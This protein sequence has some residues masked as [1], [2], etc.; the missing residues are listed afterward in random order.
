MRKLSTIQP[1]LLEPWL[2]VEHAKELQ[3]ISEILEQ[4]PEIQELILQDLHLSSGAQADTGADGLSADQVLRALLIKQ[5]NG[6]SYQELAFHLADSS[7]YRTFCRFGITDPAP[8]RSCLA[9]NI[10]ALRAE[11]LEA[12]NRILV[13]AA[14]SEGIDNGAKVRIDCTVTESNIHHPTDSALLWD[15]VRVLVRL[16]GQARQVLGEVVVFHDRT[17]RAKRRRRQINDTYRRHVRAKAYL[18]LLKLAE[19]TCRYGHAVRQVIGLQHDG[20]GAVQAGVLD[21]VAARLDQ[22]LPLVERVIDQTRRRVVEGERVPAAEKVVSIFEPHTDI[23]NKGGRD[24]FY[25]HKI[26]LTAGRSCM[27]LDCVVLAGNPPDSALAV[28]MVKRQHRLFGRVPRQVAADGAFASKDNLVSIK[29]LGVQDV[30]FS[31]GK[32]LAVS[33]MATSSWVY[34]RLRNFRAG[35]EGVISLLKRVFGMARCPY[36]SHSS[37]KGYVWSC[38]LASNLMVIARHKLA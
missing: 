9:A 23:I 19:E 25:G 2:D 12:I 17:R 28:E 22:Y 18:D 10:K 33:D 38:I 3:A 6:F 4:R 31:K 29:Q 30:V 26:A 16:M 37:F 5:I 11:T 34:R 24:T 32:G 35:I 15:G 20:V 13:L 27:V 36:R 14:S 8:S 7:T 1:A 21:S